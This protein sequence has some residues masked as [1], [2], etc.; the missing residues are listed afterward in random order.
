MSTKCSV[1]ITCFVIY[2]SG[3]VSFRPAKNLPILSDHMKVPKTTCGYLVSSK[4]AGKLCSALEYINAAQTEIHE[5]V[6]EQLKRRDYHNNAALYGSLGLIGVGVASS[7]IHTDVTK[8]LA[9]ATGLSLASKQY[10]NFDTQAL[11][12]L[13]MN[14]GLYCVK[15]RTEAV[16]EA[17]VERATTGIENNLPP[18][19]AEHELTNDFEQLKRALNT[20]KAAK[21]ILISDNDLH[22]KLV[23]KK[24]PYASKDAF[25]ESI[26]PV[27][28]KGELVQR[29]LKR[30]HADVELELN[31][32]N[33]SLLKKY[34]TTAPDTDAI[35]NSL[36]QYV[37]TVSAGT[38][39]QPT[40]PPEA[41]NEVRNVQPD[42]HRRP[43]SAP[44][45]NTDYINVTLNAMRVIMDLQLDYY[46]DNAAAIK[47]CSVTHM[48]S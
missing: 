29:A 18:V 37:T 13:A 14:D 3:C 6:K 17:F 46:I 40:E 33:V 8:I 16:G 27:L 20:L 4:E 10:H 39:I 19:D 11:W 25:I 32:I 24:L 15:Q 12:Y 48:G 43:R 2:L 28:A 23:L 7:S 44:M 5:I 47:T 36:R 41:T 42:G 9:G 45:K 1:L 22:K 35:I 34:I 21:V 38:E 31:R 26:D 30:S